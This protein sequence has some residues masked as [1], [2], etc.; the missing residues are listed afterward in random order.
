MEPKLAPVETKTR[1]L[2]AEETAI[3][4]E[5]QEA[6]RMFLRAQNAKNAAEARYERARV[7]MHDMA[8]RGHT[9]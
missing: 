5:F 9:L 8:V 2:D 3:L 1:T 4:E 7:A 6:T